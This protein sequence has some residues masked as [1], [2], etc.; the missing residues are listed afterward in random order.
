VVL[1]QKNGNST[2]T[3]EDLAEQDDE[4]EEKRQ[5]YRIKEAKIAR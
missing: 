2:C 3:E 5:N 4:E 1:D